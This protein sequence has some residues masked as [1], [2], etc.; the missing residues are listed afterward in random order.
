VT[1]GDVLR[2]AVGAH[3]G[4]RGRSALTAFAMAIGVAAVVVL[5][6]LGDGA[7]R[8]VTEEFASLGTNLLIVLPG[9]SETT[10]GPPPLLGETPRDLTIADAVAMTRS[11]AVRRMAPVNVGAA[12][13]GWGGRQR[14]TMILGS[15]ST[16]FPIRHIE[17]AQG[18]PLPRGDPERGL[19]VCVIGK[20]VRDEL[21]GPSR[22]LG[23][24]LAVGD[25]R[26]RVIGILASGGVSV[27]VNFSDVVI[28]P[29][30]SAQA[31]FNTPSLFRVLVESRSRESVAAAKE[32][33]LR[34]VKERHD[35]EDDITVIS[36]DS[37]LGAFDRIFR[38][39]TLA[40]AGIAAISLAVAGI[41]IMNVML[42]SV[43]RRRSEI[44][45]LKAL[46][47][48][49]GQVRNAFLAEAGLL[50]LLGAVAGLILG[51]GGAWIIEQFYPILSLTPPLWA[52]GSAFAVSITTG[53]AFGLLPASR[54]ARLDPVAAL[55]KR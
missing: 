16:L 21:F 2:F 3:L 26:F 22:A 49:N 9:R 19:S 54:A 11:R 35:G 28:I 52:A 34:I 39:L 55:S 30:A 6:A 53:L 23:Q 25:R 38:T 44:G 8:Y 50:S 13:V 51:Y 18:K 5:T 31:L 42:I 1:V 32:D 20:K 46:G 41:L 4:Y 24:W 7:R 17:M 10:G 27:G 14:E 37:V 12:P 48:T 29:V 33:V 43:A 36:Q 47:A 40:V 15:T 45:L